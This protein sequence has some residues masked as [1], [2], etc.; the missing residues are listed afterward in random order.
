[1]RTGGDGGQVALQGSP[2]KEKLVA[3][4]A[5]PVELDAQGKAT[6]SFDIPQFNG[7]A[8]IMAVAWT[9]TGIGH[10]V[11]DVIIRDPVV[12]TASAPKFLSPSDISQ[13]RLTL[14]TRMAKPVIIRS[15]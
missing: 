13:L 7:T 12:V 8:R 6:I 5:G 9:K 4:F 14:P 10:A 3:F 15:T 1:M 2:P 11:S